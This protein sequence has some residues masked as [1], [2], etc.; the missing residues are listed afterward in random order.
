[1]FAVVKTGGK[2]YKVSEGDIVRVD[3]LE[4]KV[5][6]EVALGQALMLGVGA[7]VKI[8]APLVEGS[9]VTGIVTRQ[10]RDKKIIVFKM[11]RRKKYRNKNGHRQSLTELKITNISG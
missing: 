9:S 5:G 6:D 2:Q 1:M 4:G 3:K 10:F 11:K 8:G 7:E